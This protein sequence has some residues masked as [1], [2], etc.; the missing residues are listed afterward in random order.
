MADW[1]HL[2]ESNLM[3]ESPLVKRLLWSGLL[4]G[5]HHDPPGQGADV[6]AGLGRRDQFVG[7]DEAPG[8]MLPADQRLHAQQPARRQVDHRE[9]LQEGSSGERERRGRVGQHVSSPA[10][11]LGSPPSP[12]SGGAVA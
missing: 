6:T 9:E 12:H 5:L 4:A 1:R 10:L 11:A 7:G 3:K 2:L 8:R